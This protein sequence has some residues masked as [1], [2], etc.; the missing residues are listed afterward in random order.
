[1]K[2]LTIANE[3]GG[4]GKSFIATQF[5]YYCALKF[6]LRTALIDLDQQGNASVTL[7]A[8]QSDLKAQPCEVCACDLILGAS[9][10]S[11]FP[12]F[13]LFAASDE[14]QALESQGDAEHGRFVDNL[15]KSLKQLEPFFDVVII[16]TNPSPDIRSNAGLIVCTHLVSPIQLA[17]EAIDGISRLFDRISNISQL[18]SNLP[19]GFIGM[20]PNMVE[21]G[22]FQVANGK[23]LLEHFGKLLIGVPE[24]KLQYTKDEQGQLK[25]LRTA[26]G[27]CCSEKMGFAAVK[28]HAGIAEAQ[29]LG[30]PIWEMQG[31]AAAWSEMK[32]AFFAILEAMNIER[33]NEL[34]PQMQAVID[35][36]RQLYGKSWKKIVRQFW[37]MDNAQVLPGL[38]PE[39]IKILREAKGYAP[40]SLVK[41]I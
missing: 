35:E 15:V 8:Y 38:T 6:R 7:N 2:I 13:A 9:L 24:I 1:M 37:L 19:D 23:L 36:C 10:P 32:R 21:A 27:L 3:K 14:L 12:P 31:Q 11:K 20:L 39:K 28:R 26:K 29:A 41:E 25:P 33:A 5:A 30:L 18:N 16:D 4:V 40:L 22:N 17:K 34:T